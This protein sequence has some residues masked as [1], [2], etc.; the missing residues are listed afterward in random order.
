MAAAEKGDINEGFYC[1]IHKGSSDANAMS[2][3]T[4]KN[5]KEKSFL[6]KI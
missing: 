3:K 4:V 2:R 5:E 6:I 1:V